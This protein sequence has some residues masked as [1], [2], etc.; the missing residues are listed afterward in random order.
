MSKETKMTEYLLH[1]IKKN[2]VSLLLIA[3]EECK[4]Y[5]F[6]MEGCNIDIILQE[7][8]KTNQKEYL[9]SFYPREV[10]PENVMEYQVLPDDMNVYIDV[11]T[12]KVLRAHPSI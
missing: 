12:K 11:K 6:D 1:E 8:I 3:I 4:K 10:T 2:E 9:V 5:N 7:N